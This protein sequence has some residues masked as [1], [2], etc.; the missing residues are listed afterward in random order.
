MNFVARLPPRLKFFAVRRIPHRRF[1]KL[2]AR[3][4]AGDQPDAYG[5][6]PGH[7]PKPI[8]LNLV[9]PVGAGRGLVGWGWEARFDEARPSGG[10]TLTHTL[11]QH[12]PNLGGRGAE[13]NQPLQ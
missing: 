9:N 4:P 5:I 3:S 10:Q 8:V 7:E 1:T 2:V 13:S 11:D 12:A 6:A